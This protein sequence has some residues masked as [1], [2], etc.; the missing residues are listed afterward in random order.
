VKENSSLLE[1]K[2]IS[3]QKAMRNPNKKKKPHQHL[4]L[5]T[6]K[7]EH[8]SRASFTDDVSPAKRMR[9]NSIGHARGG[10]GM[11]SGRGYGN[12][13]GNNFGGGNGKCTNGYYLYTQ[14]YFTLR[15]YSLKPI[16][17]TLN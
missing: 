8:L 7:K 14:D 9:V 4:Y 10:P 1:E 2:M 17:S 12:M 16:I 13:P 5:I 15:Y 11:L 6:G 3:L